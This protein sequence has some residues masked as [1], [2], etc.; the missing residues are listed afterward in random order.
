MT[1]CIYKS[2]LFRFLDSTGVNLLK[3]LQNTAKHNGKIAAVIASKRIRERYVET[4]AILYVLSLF[5]LS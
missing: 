3:E 5:E 2:E 4:Y 1:I